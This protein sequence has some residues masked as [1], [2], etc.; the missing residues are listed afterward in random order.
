MDSTSQREHIIILPARRPIHACVVTRPCMEVAQQLAALDASIM[1]APMRLR[2]ELREELGVD[3]IRAAPIYQR[4]HAYAHGIVR[5]LFYIVCEWD[6][7]PRGAEG[8]QIAWVPLWRMHC[9]PTFACFG[10]A[11]W[12]LPSNRPAVKHIASAVRGSFSVQSKPRVACAERAKRPARE[13]G[14]RNQAGLVVQSAARA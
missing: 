1:L 4:E 10:G 5:V 12:L 7:T 2:R 8:Q 6:G 9:V 3:I 13:Q 11:R 14:E